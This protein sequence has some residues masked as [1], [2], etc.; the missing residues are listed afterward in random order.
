MKTLCD[1]FEAELKRRAEDQA[2]DDALKA[3]LIIIG[4]EIETIQRRLDGEDADG[5]CPPFEQ[6]EAR[7]DRIRQ[8][9]ARINAIQL[10]IAKPSEVAECIGGIV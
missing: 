2:R 3:E 9:H 5:Y 6:I 8:L 10:A 1:Y 7:R 4:R